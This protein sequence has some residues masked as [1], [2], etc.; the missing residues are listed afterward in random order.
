MRVRP[1]TLQSYGFHLHL[2]FRDDEE[3]FHLYL[4]FRDDEEMFNIY[5]AMMAHGSAW[6]H[7]LSCHILLNRFSVSALA[8][9]LDTGADLI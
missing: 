2:R 3:M 1:I 9:S 7:A 5:D 4:R 8:V 6:F